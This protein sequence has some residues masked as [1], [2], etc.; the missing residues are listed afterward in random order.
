MNQCCSIAERRQL[1]DEEEQLLR[2]EEE[3]IERVRRYELENEIRKLE[4]RKQFMVFIQQQEEE[5]KKANEGNI[6]MMQTIYSR[7]L[8]L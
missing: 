8:K 4:N 2:E 6:R 1:I 5:S 7:N 3:R